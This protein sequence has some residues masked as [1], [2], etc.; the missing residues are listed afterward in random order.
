MAVPVTA[1]QDTVRFAVPGF[2]YSVLGSGKRPNNWEHP[3]LVLEGI[4]VSW[5]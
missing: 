1:A 5:K 4:V 3:T 2:G